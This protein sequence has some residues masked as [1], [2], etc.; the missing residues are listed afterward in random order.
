VFTSIGSATRSFK[1]YNTYK[2]NIRITSLKIAG[3]SNS[4]FRMNVDGVSGTEF[5]D[6]EIPPNDSIYVFV[7]VTIDPN[8]M[9]LPFVVE[10]SILFVTNNNEQKVQLVS[11]GQNA[12][13]YD[14]VIICD[15]VWEN[16]LPY[17][18]YNSILVDTLCT[19]TIKEGCRI[20]MHAG[21]SFYVLGTLKVQGPSDSVVTFEA[22]R[23]ES[24]FNEIPGQWEGISF[25]RSSKANEITYA[26]IK[27][28]NYGI[29]VGLQSTNADLNTYLGDVTR[30]DLLLSNT[31]VFDCALS[32]ILAVNAEMDVTNTLIYN[33]GEN[34]VALASGGL[35][36]F[37]HCTL[38]NYGS[39]YLAHRSPVL[40]VSD[41]IAFGTD[42]VIN[43]LLEANFIN[44]IVYG[45]IVE[46]K[47]ISISNDGG[48]PVFNYNFNHCILRTELSGPHFVDCIINVDPK[49]ANINERNYCPDTLSAAI[50][51]GIDIG[52]LEDLTG[53]VRPYPGTQ[54]D[55]GCYETYFE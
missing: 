42:A 13:F 29:L 23:L 45:S 31:S 47:E 49:F 41:F 1:I 14:G 30:P 27:N 43:D 24:F 36:N 38:A 50:N 6:V 40:S 20:Y 32:G 53:T 9:Q 15:E 7:E 10:D 21:S 35:Y 4:L 46:G 44:T 12:V 25:L 2:E 54:P 5:K 17:V 51:A 19:L 33:I 8:A 3:G 34:N 48:A 22:D 37:K 39:A 52:V 26:N 28:A 16:N 18:I 55:I 11:W